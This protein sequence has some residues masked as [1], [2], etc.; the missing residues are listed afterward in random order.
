MPRNKYIPMGNREDESRYWK[1]LRQC[2]HEDDPSTGI[3]VIA[4]MYGK[5][6]YDVWFHYR[7]AKGDCE[8]S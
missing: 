5:N 4:K 1:G 7:V 2:C 8:L 6:L 3:S